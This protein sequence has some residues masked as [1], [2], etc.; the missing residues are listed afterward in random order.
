M[1]IDLRVSPVSLL[2]RGSAPPG[3]REL[4]SNERRASSTMLCRALTG[5]CSVPGSTGT[6]S[7]TSVSCGQGSAKRSASRS[8]SWQT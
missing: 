5:D 3:R 4:I 1:T 2:R 6:A 8:S 7:I